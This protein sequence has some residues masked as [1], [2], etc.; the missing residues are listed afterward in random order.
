MR[1]LRIRLGLRIGVLAGIV[2]GTT[3][4][5][6]A[7]L[8]PKAIAAGTPSV[9]YVPI[10]ID[11]IFVVIPVGVNLPPDPGTAGDATIQGIDSNGNGVRD[12]IE[13]AIV[14]AYPNKPQA[15]PVLF[16]MAKYYQSVIVNRTSPST[17]LDSFSSLAALT[18]CLQAAIGDTSINGGIL[19]PWTLNT[20]DRSVAY[21]TALKTIKGMDALSKVM[22]CP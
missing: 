22:A 19:R 1:R 20:Y 14:F 12:D 4:L 17:V 16:Q 5:S 21:I 7:L 10:P 15:Y 3:A 2:I 9:A 8:A 11:D 18:P 6:S 13:R